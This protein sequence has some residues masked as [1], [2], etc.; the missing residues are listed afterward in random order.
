MK[1]ILLLTLI[2]VCF[3]SCST[4]ALLTANFESETI[5]ALPAQNI[6]GAPSGDEITY[7]T[8]LEPRIKVVASTSPGEK[9]VEFSQNTA[10]GLTSSNQFLGFRGIST[11]LTQPLYFLYTARQSGTFN[12]LIVDLSDGSGALLARM[13]IRNTGD[14]SLVNNLLPTPSVR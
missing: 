7:S 6:P 14:V 13:Y 11:N 10:P 4:S 5:G 9:A 1:N 12:A 2:S 8:Q 3:F